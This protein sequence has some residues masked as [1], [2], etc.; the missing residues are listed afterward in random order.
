MARDRHPAD[1][2]G[3]RK[4]EAEELRKHVPGQ[5]DLPGVLAAEKRIL[6]LEKEGKRTGKNEKRVDL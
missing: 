5:H 6:H 2:E 1:A 4:R 3:R